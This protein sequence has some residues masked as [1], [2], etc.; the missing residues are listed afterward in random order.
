MKRSMRTIAALTILAITSSAVISNPTVPACAGYIDEA[1]TDE[2]GFEEAGI[3]SEAL[4]AAATEGAAAPAPYTS[5]APATDYAAPAPGTANTAATTLAKAAKPTVEIDSCTAYVGKPIT[6]AHPGSYGSKWKSKNKKIAAVTVRKGAMTITPKKAGT[7]EIYATDSSARYVYTVTVVD[8]VSLDISEATVTAGDAFNLNLNYDDSEEAYELGYTTDT[9]VKWSSSKKSVATVK[10]GSIIT[11]KAGKATITA[12]YKKR[13]YKCK[14]TVTKS[15]AP[16]IL[17][18]KKGTKTVSAGTM[19]ASTAGSLSEDNYNI[20]IPA[21]TFAEN[22]NVIIKPS[23]K[24]KLSITAEGKDFARLEEPVKIS[25]KLDGP[26]LDKDLDKYMGVYYFE[27]QK[28]YTVPDRDKLRQGILEYEVYHFSDHGGEKLSDADIAAGVAY[29]EALIEV[30]RD[31]QNKFVKDIVE[32]GF[33]SIVKELG[34]AEDKQKDFLKKFSKGTQFIGLARALAEGNETEFTKEA[35]GIILNTIGENPNAGYFV[36]AVGSASEVA[37]CLERGD[38]TGAATAVAKAVASN[39]PIVKYTQFAAQICRTTIDY[40]VSCETDAAYKLYCNLIKEGESGYSMKN[41][42]GWQA[43]EK[44]MAAPLRQMKIDAMNNF[45]TANNISVDEITADERD[46][47]EA[48]V[49]NNLEAQF[50]GRYERQK[51][52]EDR[53]KETEKMFEE[54]RKVGLLERGDTTVGFGKNDDLEIRL[55]RLLNLRGSVESLME[56]KTF[57]DLAGYNKMGTM[58]D[59]MKADYNRRKMAEFIGIWVENA[60]TEGHHGLDGEKAVRQALIERYGIGLELSKSEITLN[61]GDYDTLELK[62]AQEGVKWASSDKTVATVS[63][64]GVVTGKGAGTARIRARYGKSS[65][66]C[67]VTVIGG[68]GVPTLVPGS[69]RL[70]KKGDTQTI[71]LRSV[72]AD[73]EAGSEIIPMKSKSSWSKSDKNSCIEI[74][75]TSDGGL[76]ITAVKESGTATVS[77]TYDGIKYSCEV[78]VGEEEEENKDPVRLNWTS[79]EFEAFMQQCDLRLYKLKDPKE[80]DQQSNR[81]YLVVDNWTVTG[82]SVIKK[83]YDGEDTVYIKA[84]CDGESTVS[85]TY[86]GKTYSC[87]FT[88]KNVGSVVDVGSLSITYNPKTDGYQGQVFVECEGTDGALPIDWGS[89]GLQRGI[90]FGGASDGSSQNVRASKPVTSNYIVWARSDSLKKTFKI[91]VTLISDEEYVMKKK[92]YYILNLNSGSLTLRAEE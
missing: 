62:G 83:Q 60:W 8:P 73:D 34:V 68:E 6:I 76:K 37:D 17:K 5:A 14:V 25:I 77:V 30:S 71:Y 4:N 87:K 48:M 41:G 79:Y 92:P 56:G 33:M 61:A 12:T 66:F 58:T 47:I 16:A 91:A 32:E 85:C 38:T 39:I 50:R 40:Y 26:V 44:Q 51:E 72:V 36:A 67:S 15:G 69:V 78:T 80:K 23:G 49:R 22:T 46:K 84:F 74:T 18:L 63:E 45:A 65:Y 31:E 2:D 24:N 9:K 7:T 54:F 35:T 75:T 43:V 53:Q 3:F 19:T 70:A 20:E 10:N 57:S 42:F 81:E 27:G 28:I 1:C 29:R 13:K 89:D 59:E 90:V 21:G 52:I 86:G 55:N 88:V 82:D 64:D 11:K